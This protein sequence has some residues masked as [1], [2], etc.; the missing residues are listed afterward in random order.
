MEETSV[1]PTSDMD[2]AQLPSDT[3]L[4]QLLSTCQKYHEIQTRETDDG[5]VIFECF[6]CPFKRVLDT[7]EEDYIREHGYMT[8]GLL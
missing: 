3:R 4:F 8:P 7:K 6:E 5:V 2:M 1:T